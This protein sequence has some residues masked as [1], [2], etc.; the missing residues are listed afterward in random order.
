MKR[1]LRP[2]TF[3]VFALALSFIWMRESFSPPPSEY[4]DINEIPIESQV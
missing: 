4:A 3:L 2:K 1:I